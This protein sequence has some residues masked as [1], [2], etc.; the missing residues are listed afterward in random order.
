M[1]TTSFSG[2]VLQ[3]SLGGVVALCVWIAREQVNEFVGAD[4]AR[5]VVA[6]LLARLA[7]SLIQAVLDGQH[8][9]HVS[10]LLSPV[11]TFGR[12]VVQVLLVLAG[13]GIAGAFAGY[14]VGLIVA[15]AVGLYFVEV[16]LAQPTHREFS[17]LMS[18]AK[19]SWVGTLKGRAFLSMD[20][21]I[22]AVFVSN[23]LVGIYE[24]S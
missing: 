1:G 23:S 10:S 5:A 3:L 22:L 15:V 8:F 21:I 6:I 20:T 9:V 13:F 24:V 4:A 12:S 11:E 7:F 17:R 18:Y 16:P 14:L 19:L 2:T